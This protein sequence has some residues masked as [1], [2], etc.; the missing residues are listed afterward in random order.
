MAA[1]DAEE[2]LK[3]LHD[4]RETSPIVPPPDGTS[5]SRL[6]RPVTLLSSVSK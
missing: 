6:H 1:L 2:F 5:G 4:E 3:T